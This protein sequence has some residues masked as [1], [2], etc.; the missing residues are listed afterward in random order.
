M[1]VTA[2][3]I[4]VTA[5]VD[6]RQAREELIGA[7]EQ[8]SKRI[9][10][11]ITSSTGAAFRKTAQETARVQ[12]ELAQKRRRLIIGN[13]QDERQRELQLIN[14]KFDEERKR[15]EKLLQLRL[16]AGELTKQQF[17]A[18]I[19]EFD[20]LLDRSR[21]QAIAQVD[22]PQSILARFRKLGTVAGTALGLGIGAGVIGGV[23]ALRKGLDEA[24]GEAVK[25][26]RQM[27]DVRKVTGL[28]ATEIDRLGD[29]LLALQ[30]TFGL[31]REGL[32]D[33]AFVAGQLGIEGVENIAA[34]VEQVA[35]IA[36]VTQFS[37]Q[38]AAEALARISNIFNIPITE[39]N[40]LASVLNDLE[41][42]TTSTAP[43]I[44]DLILRVGTAATQLGLTAGEVA[45][46]G[47]TI[48]DAGIEVERGGTGLRNTLLR[49]RTEGEALSKVAKVTRDEFDT[50]V[51]TDAIAALNL[52]LDG[53]R[54]MPRV[55]R[56]IHIDEVFGER[57]QQIINVL[58]TQTDDLTRNLERATEAQ[59]EGTSINRAY[60]VTLES[61][62]RQWDIF[63]GRLSAAAVTAGQQALPVLS[64]LLVTMNR[65]GASSTQIAD[66][67][68][69]TTDQL[70]RTPEMRQLID[71]YIELRDNTERTAEETDELRRVSEELN[72][73]WPQFSTGVKDAAGAYVIFAEALKAA[74]D[75]QDALLERSRRADLE[76]LVDSYEKAAVEARTWRLEQEALTKA[77]E[78]GE[79][80][81]LG[82]PIGVGAAQ[83]FRDIN[84]ALA[85]AADNASRLEAEARNAIRELG[86][87]FNLATDEK[88]DQF[89]DF[90]VAQ[91]IAAE[92]ASAKFDRFAEAFRSLVDTGS[93]V[94]FDFS[95]LG[96]EQV[97]QEIERIRVT[98]DSLG[99]GQQFD[100]LNQE[101]QALLRREQ[102]IL[103]EIEER[104]LQ[105][106]TLAAEARE[107]LQESAS[108]AAESLIEKE[109]NLAIQAIEDEHERRIATIE[110]GFQRE[111]ESIEA[112]LDL[113]RRAGQIS[114]DEY[115]SAL[116]DFND[117]INNAQQRALEEANRRR[118]E[119]EERLQQQ[120]SAT[121]S[122]IAKVQR[123]NDLKLFQERQD[124]ELRLIEDTVEKQE[125]AI[126]Q[127]FRARIRAINNTH[128]AELDRIDREVESATEAEVLILQAGLD[129][130]AALAEAEGQRI[131]ATRA[132]YE[133]L[134]ADLEQQTQRLTSQIENY[135][136]RIAGVLRSA[137]TEEQRF[138]QSDIELT[139]FR[140]QQRLEA[141]QDN[142]AEQRISQREY[143]LE[144]RS[145]AEDRAR[146]E[147]EV[148]EDRAGRLSRILSGLTQFAIDEAVRLTIRLGAEFAARAIL[149]KTA[150]ATTVAAVS[151][152]MKAI[153]AS[154]GGAA[155]AVSIA[156]VG[157]A[158]VTGTAAALSG[159]A[160]VKAAALASTF[161]E[162]GYAPGGKDAW[163]TGQGGRYTPAGV[164]H[165]G[166]FVFSQPVVSGQ[167]REFW[168]LFGWLKQGHRL[169]D[170]LDSH[171]VARSVSRSSVRRLAYQTGG[172]AEAFVPASP[173]PSTTVFS[174][175]ATESG[176]KLLA[177]I[178]RLGDRIEGIEVRLEI[179]KRTQ[180]AILK[181]GQAYQRETET[182]NPLVQRR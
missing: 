141:L 75:Q 66:A 90:F 62:S 136:S 119:Q 148:E 61:V 1:A 175:A 115:A 45:A 57:N 135:A 32:T 142:L 43:E 3:Q 155:A 151:A 68:A 14:L 44:A 50:L 157:A 64:D 129:R 103:D 146:F 12:E 85:A 41:D 126:E 164:V 133:K 149:A 124:A 94:T 102:Q 176:G 88:R 138:T 104:R 89:V 77:I 84:T 16:R 46:F 59:E 131:E 65:L 166:E 139:R 143:D 7:L 81:V 15:I 150:L 20:V 42:T 69:L 26:E 182:R 99:S 53:L 154:A 144:I 34:F 167:V 25:F 38:E 108:K 10:S 109:R 37:E 40:R 86:A 114:A 128:E 168:R 153:A 171:G 172:L 6:V 97:R 179:G 2:E 54:E 158:A 24:V 79:R 152:S 23:Q 49:L 17:K 31:D 100:R 127:T 178:D 39:I 55:L 51:R 27:I 145:L 13:I 137:L 48:R 29:A 159:I 162:G 92:D 63:K 11:A 111:R 170:L 130:N 122:R 19:A 118:L 147:E 116:A 106:E 9:S 4:R 123:D 73:Q 134:A 74:L 60:A 163:Y 58:L 36:E 132:L 47:A 78:R 87:I 121:Q 181:G 76:K 28:S 33:I 161:A 52:Y 174:A 110:L 91:G 96:L 22:A 30:S 18:S 83:S 93:D 21:Q 120:I 101:L 169:S 71:R 180:T 72:A 140:F 8:A 107:K 112:L 165:A 125:A 56:D 173:V 160:A 80:A 156:T 70:S 117:R 67:I 177:A 35:K 95:N 98:M 5:S 113:R 105:Q 82:A